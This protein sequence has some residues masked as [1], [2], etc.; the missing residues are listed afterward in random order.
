MRIGV[1]CLRRFLHESWSDC[2]TDGRFTN[3]S[4]SWSGGSPLLLPPPSATVAASPDVDS[5]LDVALYDGADVIMLPSL[6]GSFSFRFV[7]ISSFLHANHAPD[8][9]V[10]KHTH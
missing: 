7:L 8:V 5:A 3:R 9:T 6:L 10:N 4:D 1:D 2:A